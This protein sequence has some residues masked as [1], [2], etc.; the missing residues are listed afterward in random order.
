MKSKRLLR[1]LS[2]LNNHCIFLAAGTLF[3]LP[4]LSVAATEYASVKPLMLEAIDAPSGTSLGTLTGPIAEKFA[5]T[6]GSRA[7]VQ[8]AVTT[9]KNFR[10]EGCKRLNV[11]LFQDS[12]P[13]KEGKPTGVGFDY[14]INLCRDGSPPVEG[15]DLESLGGALRQ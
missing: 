3:L 2:M 5:T 8:V 10:Q 12:V 14:G 6:T 1:K 13:T 9:L 7:P 15:M 4:S 11:R